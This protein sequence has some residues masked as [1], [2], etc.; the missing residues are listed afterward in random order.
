MQEIPSQPRSKRGPG[1][2]V[3][4]LSGVSD[5]V[6][7]PSPWSIRLINTIIWTHG[8]MA[9]QI[10]GQIR[11][12]T[13]GEIPLRERLHPKNLGAENTDKHR[14]HGPVIGSVFSPLLQLLVKGSWFQKGGGICRG[15]RA[16]LGTRFDPRSR[17]PLDV[18]VPQVAAPA[19]RTQEELNFA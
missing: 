17:A 13:C 10:R 5:L 4:P 9:N 7:E 19:G 8:Q 2:A 1:D 16:A 6:L 15:V 14:V 18:P 11:A 3:S 12:L